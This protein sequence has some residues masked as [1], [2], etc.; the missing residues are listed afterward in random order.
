MRR[1]LP[2]NPFSK[3]PTCSKKHEEI[4]G[5]SYVLREIT[6]P[7]Q[8]N[9]HLLL[10]RFCSQHARN[11]TPLGGVCAQARLRSIELRE[12]SLSLFALE[13]KHCPEPLALNESHQKNVLVKITSDGLHGEPMAVHNLVFN[14]ST[15]FRPAVSLETITSSQQFHDYPIWASFP[16]KWAEPP[17]FVQRER[18]V[19]FQL[20]PRCS[21]PTRS[22]RQ[23]GLHRPRPSMANVHNISGSWRLW[24]S[25]EWNQRTSNFLSHFG[26]VISN[27]FCLSANKYKFCSFYR[28]SI[29]RRLFL[30]LLMRESN[31]A[32]QYVTCSEP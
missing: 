18:T 16:S 23:W 2:N 29:F 8:E 14:L 19:T 20:A 11:I 32:G 15:L 25:F 31:L 4:L 21:S 9:S 7:Y 24:P 12:L 28:A 1:T 27:V 22:P 3:I 6:L 10:G 30:A 13:M 5:K 17:A 26:S